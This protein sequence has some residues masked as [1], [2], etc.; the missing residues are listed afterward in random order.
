MHIIGIYQV[1]LR[2]MSGISRAYLRYISGIS[3]AYLKYISDIYQVYL[4]QLLDI[5]LPAR[6]IMM[7]QPKKTYRKL[8]RGK[9]GGTSDL[10]AKEMFKNEN[11]NLSAS[12]NINIIHKTSD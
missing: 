12:I 4:G 9:Y 1:Y 8:E 11:D 10:L 5:D 2:Y 3:L 6:S 7:L